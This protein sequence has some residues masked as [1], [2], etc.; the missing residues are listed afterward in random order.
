MNAPNP[1]GCYIKVYDA[2]RFGGI[3]D[4]I[5]GPM[6]YPMLDALPNGA[7]WRNRIRSVQVGPAATASVWESRNFAGKSMQLRTDLPYP[8]LPE[9]FV[10]Q[11]ESMDIRCTSAAGPPNV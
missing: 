10:A 1:N 7:S 3:S 2:E 8:T 5:N 4:F 9:V 11:I 6:R